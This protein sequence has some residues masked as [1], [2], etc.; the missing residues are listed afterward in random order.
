MP[1]FV[2]FYIFHFS[3]LGIAIYTC[4]CFSAI[5][6]TA[7]GRKVRTMKPSMVLHFISF[8]EFYYFLRRTVI[9]K[10]AENSCTLLNY[11][12]CPCI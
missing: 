12:W 3:T 6:H 8:V 11:K 7:H 2:S 1:D 9:L 10:L 4:K 5:G